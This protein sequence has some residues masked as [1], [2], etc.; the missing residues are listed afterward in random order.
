MKIIE[1]TVNWF[2]CDSP[3]KKMDEFLESFSILSYEKRTRA[4]GTTKS[5]FFGHYF[6]THLSYDEI[7][8]KVDKFLGR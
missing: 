8:N 6:K 4:Y 2:G 3:A 7:R 5:G 1:V